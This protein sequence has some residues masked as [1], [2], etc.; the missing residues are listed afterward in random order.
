MRP[1]TKKSIK[2]LNN[3]LN[4]LKFRT[5]SNKLSDIIYA[6]NNLLFTYDN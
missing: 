4:F 3:I 2:I 1:I 5:Q 6:G